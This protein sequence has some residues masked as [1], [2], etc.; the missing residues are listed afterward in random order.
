[1]SNGIVYITITYFSGLGFLLAVNELIYRFRKIPGEISRKAAHM[2]ATLSTLPFPYLFDSHWYV[3]ILASIF[4]FVLLLTKS[5][6]QLGSIHDI[7]R[8]SMGSYLLPVAIYI[9]FLISS[10][11]DNRL[12]FILPMLILAISD[13]L[14]ALVGISLEKYNHR[15]ILFKYDTHKSVFGT[16]TFFFSAFFIST[17]AIYFINDTITLSDV[18]VTLIVALVSSI[19]ELLCRWGLDNLLIPL[20]VILVL[21]LVN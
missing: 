5:G 10:L 13:P 21:I 14:A 4:F 7:E 1:M 20:S 15:I 12:L 18:F 9:A 11:L 3:M 6:K 2:L 17:I 19:T 8:S 16:S